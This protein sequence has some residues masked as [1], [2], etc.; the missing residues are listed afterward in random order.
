MRL[1]ILCIAP[2]LLLIPLCLAGAANAVSILADTAV[3]AHIA[4]EL[5]LEAQSEMPCAV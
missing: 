3:T 4:T 5:V 1:R 2:L